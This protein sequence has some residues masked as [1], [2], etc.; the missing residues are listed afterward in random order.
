MAE[1]IDMSCVLP[2]K[3]RRCGVLQTSAMQGREEQDES[4]E[5]QLENNDCLFDNDD[6]GQHFFGEH[7]IVQTMQ[8]LLLNTNK[9]IEDLTS[10]CRA[11]HHSDIVMGMTKH[12]LLPIAG[13]K[14][15]C[16][17]YSHMNK[18][19]LHVLRCIVQNST[20]TFTATYP[21]DHFIVYKSTK[22]QVDDKILL[23]GATCI[24]MHGLGTTEAKKRGYVWKKMSKIP[25]QYHV[26]AT[27]V[28]ILY[29]CG[30]KQGLARD[31]SNLLVKHKVY[32]E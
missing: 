9:T 21:N 31:V 14:M 1:S 10:L 19:Q 17:P 4:V 23:F 11:L 2:Q 8:C 26:N 7:Q 16:I 18:S 6:W 27:I 25:L 22:Q 15:Y 28:N 30:M 32:M 20:K 5:L 13:D 29:S 24:L 3:N 12:G